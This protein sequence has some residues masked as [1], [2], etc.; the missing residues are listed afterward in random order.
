MGFKE[1]RE[2]AG[3]W[4]FFLILGI[5]VM[6]LGWTIYD[7]LIGLALIG[8]SLYDAVKFFKKKQT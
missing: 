5:A 1:I 7:T 4:I 3:W 8:F 6:I 2:S